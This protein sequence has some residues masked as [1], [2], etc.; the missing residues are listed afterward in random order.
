MINITIKTLILFEKQWHIRLTLFKFQRGSYNRRQKQKQKRKG[1]HKKKGKACMGW[2][3]GHVHLA[4]SKKTHVR[5]NFFLRGRPHQF[6][7]K[8]NGRCATRLGR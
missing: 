1:H 7:S 6:V 8:L 3:N 2:N 5:L 4:H